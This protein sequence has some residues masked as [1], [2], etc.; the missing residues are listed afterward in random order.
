MDHYESDGGVAYGK[1]A[2]LQ[3]ARFNSFMK[4]PF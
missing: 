1:E 4:E 2:T 3:H